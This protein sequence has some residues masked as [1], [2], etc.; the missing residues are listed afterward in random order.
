MFSLSRR[1]LCRC[2]ASALVVF[3]GC[4]DDKGTG[5]VPR[6]SSFEQTEELERVR[7]RNRDLVWEIS[8]LR[9]KVQMVSGAAMVRS[10]TNGLWYLDVQR[11]PFTGCA[12]D[13]F[14][15]GSRKGEASF[16]E[17]KKDGV[18]R[19][20]HPN[21][22]IRIERQWLNGELHGYLTEW[23]TQGVVL[24]RKRYQRGKEV[25]AP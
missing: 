9:L 17:G 6:T 20:W 18:E 24:S 15:D 8:R 12:V 25:A 11:K 10:K 4:S 3:P 2:L 14:E 13:K 23:D 5:Q 22:Q 21:G 1:G 19:Y 16:F 7:Q